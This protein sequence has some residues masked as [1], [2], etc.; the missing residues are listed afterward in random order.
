VS[1]TDIDDKG[2]VWLRGLKSLE[3]LTIYETG[4]SDAGLQHLDGLKK[5]TQLDVSRTDVS[6]DAMERLRLK[7]LNSMS[8]TR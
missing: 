3:S 8:I 4:V 7:V 1:N 6:L 5:L 2:I